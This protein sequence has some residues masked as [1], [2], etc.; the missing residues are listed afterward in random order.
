M[1]SQKQIEEYQANGAICIRGAVQPAMVQTMLEQLDRHRASGGDPA[2]AETRELA[3]SDRYLYRNHAWMRDFIFRAG[4]AEIAGRLMVSRTA[5]VYFD[6][7]FM[8]DGGT[9]ATTPW[10]QDRPY[11]PFRGRQIAS[12][13]VALTPSDD[14]SSAVHFVRGSHRWEKVYKP[15]AFG[16]KAVWASDAIG[17]EIP[18]FWQDRQGHE[19]LSWATEPGDVVVFGGDILH[20][21]G[22]NAARD[23]RRAALSIRYLGDDV[24]W[25]PRSGTDPIITQDDVKIRPGELA[26]GDENAFPLAWQLQDG[27][28]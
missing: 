10:H 21:A 7:V 1:I 9:S 13:W 3:F 23:R 28:A 27:P 17:E 24:S 8:R 12:V 25:D 5:R 20:A 26:S 14:N 16:T 18:D 15:Q 4:I 2:T 6:H 11:W 22:R 19:L